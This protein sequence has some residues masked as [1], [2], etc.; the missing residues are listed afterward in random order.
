MLRKYKYIVLA[1]ALG[2]ASCESLDQQPLDRL[3]EKTFWTSEKETLL[4]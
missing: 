2:L 3:S 4:R 1:C